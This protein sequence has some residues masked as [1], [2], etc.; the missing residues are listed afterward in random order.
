MSESLGDP[1]TSM[2][3]LTPQQL[4]VQENAELRELL[5][6]A[7]QKIDLQFK[8]TPLA[9]I[10][11]DKDFRVTRWN[12]AAERIFGYSAAEA[13]GQSAV[14]IVPDEAHPFV[15]VVMK[16]LLAGRG[17]GRS[18]NANITK[19]RAFIQCEWYNSSLRDI[20]GQVVGVSSLVDDITERTVAEAAQKHLQ[21]QL[22]QVQKMESLGSLA[23]GIAHDMNNVLGAI[24]GLASAHLEH[25]QPDIS[26]HKTFEAI[27]KAA[28]RGGKMVKGLLGFAR[29][30]PAED[31]IIEVNSLIRE[32]ISLLERTTLSKI[33]L[34]MTLAEDLLPIRGDAGALTH[35]FM[36]LC[37]NAVDAM[38]EQGELHFSS[39]NID[40]NWIEITVRDSG[41]GMPQD[42]LDKAFDPFFTTKQLGKGTGLGL[43]LV[44]GTVKAHQGDIELRSL[45]GC[46]TTVIMR[47]PTCS[48]EP[49][50][51]D[52]A[53]PPL[54]APA[55][56]ILQI[57]LID[58]DELMQNIL[59]S[60]LQALGHQTTTAW[61]GESAVAQLAAGFQPDII[62]LDMNMPGIGGAE[63]LVRIR[64]LLPTV[65][66]LL[67]TGRADQSALNVVA[68][69]PY[70][71]LLAKPFGLKD[72]K[73]GIERI[74][75]PLR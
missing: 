8:H 31:Q 56:N 61:N 60:L 33:H 37:V 43:S 16:E 42:V 47:F 36:N 51:A 1:P 71:M 17:G 22:Q 23:G 7:L 54:D 50:T 19:Q 53:H 59:Q 28:I 20:H 3:L 46:G 49:E 44:Y 75:N 9:V 68:A 24:L 62:I 27:A 12:P 35:A 64:S 25:K 40:A 57:L 30:S 65:P 26:A 67:S 58:D 63:T 34:V 66:V 15:A 2:R 73:L 14:F 5:S 29:Q 10:E 72:L 18:S 69:H 39:R 13:L 4:L 55:P 74:L 32:E 52:L 48:Q 21:A 38:P 45:P 11:W 70:V 41:I 6:A